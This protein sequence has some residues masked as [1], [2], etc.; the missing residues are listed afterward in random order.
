MGS[1]TESEFSKEQIWKLLDPNLPDSQGMPYYSKRWCMLS[2]SA[3]IFHLL[4]INGSTDILHQF[5][6]TDDEDN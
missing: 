4:I 6:K 1:R 2:P 3:E 5:G